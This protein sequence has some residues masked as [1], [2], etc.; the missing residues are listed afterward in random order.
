[1]RFLVLGGLL[2][3]LAAPSV[4]AADETIV[5]TTGT[6]YAAGEYTIDQGEKLDFRNDDI[7]GPSHDV[8]STANG[9]VKGQFLFAS[10][11]VGQGKT[12]FVE[13]SQ[14]LTTGSYDYFCSIHPSMKGKLVVNAAGAPKPRP[15]AAPTQPGQAPPSA[16]QTPPEPS[17]DFG[18]LRAATIVKKRRLTLKVG[19]DEAV[20][21]KVTVKIGKLTVARK[22]L[23][24]TLRGKKT[25]RLVIGKSARKA[26]KRG[27]K[28]R[29]I[30]DVTDAA[31]NPGTATDSVKLT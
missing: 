31:G 8:V 26:F 28:L 10:D 3:T 4:A 1:M 7:S 9:G 25:L 14:Y 27:R 18:S 13:G 5:A 11:T 12:S 19:A 6:R 23:K 22:S 15:G 17:L 30:V 20:A 24:L 2:A 16:D 21:M 29:V